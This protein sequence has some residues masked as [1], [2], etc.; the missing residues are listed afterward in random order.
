MANIGFARQI[1][2]KDGFLIRFECLRASFPAIPALFENDFQLV[3]MGIEKNNRLHRW[4]FV[5]I[6]P[7]NCR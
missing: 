1:I 6:L 5:F 3:F 7:L 2:T 4:L